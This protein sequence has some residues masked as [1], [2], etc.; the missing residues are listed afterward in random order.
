[1]SAFT[2]TRKLDAG[3]CVEDSVAAQG[4]QAMTLSGMPI[5]GRA[6]FEAS[7]PD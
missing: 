1:L 5:L 4:R 2:A 7:A 6:L 3:K